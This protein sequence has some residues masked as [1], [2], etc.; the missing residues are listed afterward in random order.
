[1]ILEKLLGL[2]DGDAHIEPIEVEENDWIVNDDG[3]PVGL[4]IGEKVHPFGCNADDCAVEWNGDSLGI[5][6][7]WADFTLLE[8]I[9]RPDGEPLTAS[10][11]VF[12]YKI[13]RHCV[14]PW[15]ESPCGN[16]GLK[17]MGGDDTTH[18]TL[19]YEA[20][21]EQYVGWVCLATR[22]WITSSISSIPSQ[23][24]SSAGTS[25][26]NSSIQILPPTNPWVGEL[27]FLRAGN[28]ERRYV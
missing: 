11:L 15:S 28:Q 21:N 2:A 20:L 16:L 19:H 4:K 3:K 1:M 7:L 14:D 9:Q 25:R 12:G 17:F 10:D 23:N 6:Q 26:R 18:R 27:T 22:T 8:G 5:A 24:T 13:A